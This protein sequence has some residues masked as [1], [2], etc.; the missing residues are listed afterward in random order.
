MNSS[1]DENMDEKLWHYMTLEKFLWLLD[2]KRPYFRRLTKLQEADKKEGMLPSWLQ[3]LVALVQERLNQEPRD[4]RIDAK[5]EADR[6]YVFC[7]NKDRCESY[8]MWAAYGDNGEG[9]CLQTTRSKMGRI[10][11]M[12]GPEFGQ[13]YSCDVDYIDHN[14]TGVLPES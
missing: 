1:T 14:D 11:M 3:K 10:R 9:V 5:D 12:T 2:D 7:W 13:F 6:S 8:L 4:V